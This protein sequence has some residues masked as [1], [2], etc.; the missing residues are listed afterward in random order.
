MMF[1]LEESYGRLA[2]WNILSQI[3][4]G[5]WDEYEAYFRELPLE[6]KQEFPFHSHFKREEVSLWYDNYFVIPGDY[7]VPP[8]FSS[9][10]GGDSREPLVGSSDG[11]FLQEDDTKQELLCLIGHFERVGYY[12]PLEKDVYPDHFGSLAG[13]MVSAIRE[14]IQSISNGNSNRSIEM[15]ELQEEILV[16][17]L[18]PVEDK[19][20][21]SAQERIMH[22][23]FQTFLTFYHNAV[24]QESVLLRS[25]GRDRSHAEFN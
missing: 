24:Q 12:Y 1:D 19:L 17:Y 4:L 7:F 6:V 25:A 10:S 23:F 5:E 8:Y 14:E 3:W 16:K 18:I 21:K 13:F 22:P 2:L 20:K 15:K 11:E 9:Y